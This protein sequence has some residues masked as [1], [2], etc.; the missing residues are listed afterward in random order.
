MQ[1]HPLYS[2]LLKGLPFCVFL[3]CFGYLGAYQSLP[4][5]TGAD[6][7]QYM[8]GAQQIWWPS[9]DTSY[10][11]WRAPLYLYLLGLLAHYGSYLQAGS[12]L[13]STGWLLMGGALYGMGL[14]L[15][16]PI[17]GLGLALAL[18]CLPL[19]ADGFHHLGPYP[20]IG[21]MCAVLWLAAL[22]VLKNP[23]Y[24][25]SWLMIFALCAGLASALDGRSLLI[26][27]AAIPLVLKK[28]RVKELG[29]ALAVFGVAYLPHY[30]LTAYLKLSLLPMSTKLLE[31]RRFVL[32]H[33]QGNNLH[34][35][36]PELEGLSAVCTGGSPMHTRFDWLFEDCSWAMATVNVKAWALSGLLFPLIWALG[37]MMAFRCWRFGAALV[38]LIVLGLIVPMLL[39]WHPPRYAFPLMVPFLSSLPI[40]I[41]LLADKW[42]VPRVVVSLLALLPLSLMWPA[43]LPSSTPMTW[44]FPPTRIPMAE[45]IQAAVG[46]HDFYMDCARLDTGLLWAPKSRMPTTVQTFLPLQKDCQDYIQHA[47]G[48]LLLRESDPQLPAPAEFG[49]V[50]EQRYT[51]QHRAVILWHRRP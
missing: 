36:H 15:R 6:W 18:L 49:W 22:G 11:D 50:E 35:D 25:S 40:A 24:S 43:R 30:L 28:W 33:L 32:R 13:A 10:P 47:E 29:G 51:E 44:D 19:S 27:A 14:I 38:L 8:M 9:V 39:V 48:W 45:Q 3:S 42:P 41:A 16:R 37:L 4:Y 23:K 21:G 46:T 26:V 7:A 12:W 1:S 20:L 17:L 31:Q 34:P 5:P 2:V